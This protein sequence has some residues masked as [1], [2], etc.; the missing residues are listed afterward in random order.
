MLKYSTQIAEMSNFFP[1]DDSAELAEDNEG[2]LSASS[3]S[4]RTLAR[5]P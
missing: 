2:G 5:K 3:M 4:H 1:G